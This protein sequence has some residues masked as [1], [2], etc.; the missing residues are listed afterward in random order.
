VILD[1]S[2]T[3]ALG[4]WDNLTATALHG[5]DVENDKV[6]SQTATA[7]LRQLATT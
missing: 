5:H 4:C 1:D 6:G 3:G 7:A 2:A